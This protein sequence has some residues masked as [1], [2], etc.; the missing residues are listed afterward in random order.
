MVLLTSVHLLQRINYLQI[1][2]EVSFQT[3][4]SSMD[5]FLDPPKLKTVSVGE[6]KSQTFLPKKCLK[7][8]LKFE[9]NCLG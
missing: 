9:M 7:V 3:T 2:T 6:H 4:S 5:Y 1:I 8:K